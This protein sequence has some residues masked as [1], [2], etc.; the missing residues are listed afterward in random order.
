[1]ARRPLTRE[2]RRKL[3]YKLDPLEARSVRLP[4]K[5]WEKLGWLAEHKGLQVSDLMR[6]ILGD[7]VVGVVAPRTVKT[8]EI[9]ASDTDWESWKQTAEALGVSVDQLVCDTM[10]KVV[11]LVAQSRS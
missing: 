10:G 2:D 6:S 9:R 8:G 3:G 1:M 5:T 4:A 7:A 11:R